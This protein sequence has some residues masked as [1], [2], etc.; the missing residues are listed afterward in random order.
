MQNDRF[1]G[2]A[3][4]KRKE[5]TALLLAVSVA[6]AGCGGAA[7]QGGTE[8]TQEDPAGNAEAGTV[9]AAAGVSGDAEP[10]GKTGGGAEG[11][12]TGGRAL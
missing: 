11:E 3:D 7:A 5:I 4:M 12:I 8:T 1:A 6:L 9:E 2:G 10:E